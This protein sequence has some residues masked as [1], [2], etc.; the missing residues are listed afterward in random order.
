M[1]TA[2]RHRAS[3]M[4][5][6]PAICPGLVD[7]ERMKDLLAEPDAE[8]SPAEL[9]RLGDSLS[10][11]GEQLTAAAKQAVAP[12]IEGMVGASASYLEANVLFKYNQPGKPSR[13]LNTAVVKD[14]WPDCDAN[15]HLYRDQA[16]RAASI[17]ITF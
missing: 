9:A 13:V 6:L 10:V 12:R 3:P 7:I 11:L 8:L 14:L 15:A 4:V 1:A 2:K 5:D 17:S 16:G